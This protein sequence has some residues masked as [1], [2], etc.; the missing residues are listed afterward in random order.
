MHLL[1]AVIRRRVERTVSTVAKYRYSRSRSPFDDAKQMYMI[2]GVCALAVI[3]GL[4]LILTLQPG[5]E[6]E[7]PVVEQGDGM[8][9]QLPDLPPEDS[10]VTSMGDIIIDDG[11]TPVTEFVVTVAGADG[12]YKRSA[13]GSPE[14]S[15]TVSG[16]N[17]ESFSFVLA[18]AEVSV[19]GVAYFNGET[20]AIC[21]KADGTIRFAFDA[22][23]VNVA[24][25]GAVSELGGAD[26][27]GIYL[28][29]EAATTTTTE[30]TSATTTATTT[31]P[32][33]S[34]GKYDLDS[35]KS[36][37]VKNALSGMMSEGD[38]K[39]LK[40]LMEDSGGYG[41]I[42][43]TGDA[44]KEEKGRSFNLDTEMNAVM[45]YA[46]EAGTGRE[47]VIICGDNGKQVY[48]GICDGS[49]YRYYSNDS[50][51]KSPSDAPHT[52]AQYARLRNMTLEG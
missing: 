4:V 20:T 30:T 27:N 43:G 46:N 15:L 18:L 25:E 14:V 33:P 32:P 26:A 34:S 51:R 2:I 7:I 29:A 13:E 44:S 42:Y 21:E 5:A 12:I 37:G 10:V 36:D 1:C 28:L 45:Y 24:T 40:K 48:V 41:L 3:I 47:V 38:Y 49:E 35:I 17:T 50:A 9:E 52:I 8:E 6:P 39:L 31:A 22:D 11:S 19:E 23:V 16:Q